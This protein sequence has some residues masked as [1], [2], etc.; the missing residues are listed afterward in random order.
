MFRRQLRARGLPDNFENAAMIGAAGGLDQRA[1]M[2]LGR[3]RAEND[4]EPFCMT[5][6]GLQARQRNAVSSLHGHVSRHMWQQVWSAP[7]DEEVPIGHITNGVHT[8]H[9][10]W[11]P[12][13]NRYLFSYRLTAT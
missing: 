7:S 11:R 4:N 1:F 13:W 8:P 12:R 10:S 9:P 5:V 3:V 6:L 2:A